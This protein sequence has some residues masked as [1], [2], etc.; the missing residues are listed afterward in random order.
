[1]KK[2]AY[3]GLSAVFALG[4]A[5]CDD[6]EE[7][8]PQPQTNPQESILKTED[9]VVASALGEETYDLVALNEAG[10]PVHVATV[11]TSELPD[12]YAFASI[13]EISSN[14][15]SR[16]AVVPSNVVRN[17][18]NPDNYDI[19]VKAADLQEVYYN[20]ISKG[21]KAKAIE[22]RV[23]LKTVIGKQEAYVGGASNY[24]GPY[25]LT[26]QPFPSSLVIEDNYYLLGTINDWSVATAVK[27][28]H[29]DLNPYDDPVFTLKVDISADQAA[30][31]WWWKIVPES[32]YVTGNWVEAAN[33]SYGV[34]ENGSEEPAGLLVARTDTEDCGAGCLKM[35]GQLLLTINLEE[36]T[37]E[38]TSAVDNLWTPGDANGWNHGA[39]Q[40][41]YT[42]DY[43]NYYGYAVLSPNG[44]KFTN[45]PDWNHVGYGD[46]GA[47]GVLSTDG[48]AGNLLVPAL[49]LYWCSVNT[50]SLTY[51]VT[52][53]N[54]IGLIGDATPGGWDASTA[55]TPSADY[56]TW[57]ATVKFVAGK[58][59]KFRANDA[60]DINLGG[61]LNNLEQNGP[62]IAS[63]G[64]G[65]YEVTLNLGSLPYTATI[66]KK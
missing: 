32:T 4:F 37:Y 12:T 59:F 24:Y 52:A 6:Y 44:F 29:S 66:V 28:N 5:S 13:V 47:E 7:P 63:P 41:L 54:T 2:I 26:V 49:G 36:G 31:G 58:E 56:L 57:T 22:A 51:S 34:A 43:A 20:N 53:V 14:G 33:G 64:D 11:T 16:S 15:F 9:V 48:G 19:Y 45:A 39:S 62:N 55:L 61:D 38:F 8:N 42:N 27:F 1:M 23:A 46:G 30:E 50:A 25:A 60:W 18:E 3:F 40:M 65:D 10:T 35:D 21:P 17:T